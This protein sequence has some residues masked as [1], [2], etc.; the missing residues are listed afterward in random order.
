MQAFFL[1]LSS[2]SLIG[3]KGGRKQALLTVHEN[4]CVFPLEKLCCEGGSDSCS[5][6]HDVNIAYLLPRN[7]IGIINGAS[8]VRLTVN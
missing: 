6:A 5:D 7:T 8:R 4:R 2:R 3:K 1:C